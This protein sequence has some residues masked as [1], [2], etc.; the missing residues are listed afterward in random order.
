MKWKVWI[1]GYEGS[2][3]DIDADNAEI[4]MKLGAKEQ[5]A[6]HTGEIVEIN[7]CAVFNRLNVLYRKLARISRDG[8]IEA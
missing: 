8:R 3:S 7:A 4:A 6:S 1:T 5:R 2:A